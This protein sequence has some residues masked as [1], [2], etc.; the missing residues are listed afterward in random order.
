MMDG[1]RQREERRGPVYLETGEGKSMCFHLGK[2]KLEIH[3]RKQ[4]K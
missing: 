4:S 1:E 3:G 2:R